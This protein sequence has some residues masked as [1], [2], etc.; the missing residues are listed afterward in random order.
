VS[1]KIYYCDI[2]L[3]NFHLQPN[4]S[5]NEINVLFINLNYAVREIHLFP[6]YYTKFYTN[7]NILS[8]KHLEITNL[9]VI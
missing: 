2:N 9:D 4:Q 7:P 6:R 5:S 3:A 1:F 8:K